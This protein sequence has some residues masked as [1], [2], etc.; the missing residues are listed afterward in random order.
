[1]LN[2]IDNKLKSIKRI[3]NKFFNGVNALKGKHL[4]SIHLYNYILVANDICDQN[5]FNCSRQ[6]AC[7]IS[8]K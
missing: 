8:C 3:Q 4:F 1:M 7:D 6:I 5:P 2:V